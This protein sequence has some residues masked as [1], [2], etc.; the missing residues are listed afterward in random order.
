MTADGGTSTPGDFVT[1]GR[2]VRPHG[3]RGEVVVQ[4]DTDFGDDRFRPGGRLWVG[5]TPRTIAESRPQ[6]DRWVVRFDGVDS[7]DG[8]ESLRS[9]VV[10]LPDD[11]ARRMLGAG[12]YFLHDL[13]GC[14]VETEAGTPVGS[15]AAI[16]SGAAQP[17]LG[18]TSGREEVLVPLVDEIC[19][20]VDVAGRRIVI[21]AIEGL[22]EAN[23]PER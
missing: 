3:L 13:V 22:L 6:A 20:V 8:A 19:R 15:V 11:E 16:Y 18:V 12:G 10:E 23:A 9:A 7:V 17:V 1:I 5:G 21:R 4:A 2:I 14:R